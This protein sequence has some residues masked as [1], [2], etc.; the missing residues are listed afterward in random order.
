MSLADSVM[1]EMLLVEDDLSDVFLI[2]EALA[3][4]QI[5]TRLHIAGDGVEA[6][7]FL[8]REGLHADAPRPTFVLLDLNMPRK[9]GFAVL[10]EVKSDDSLRA[11]PV[12]VFST[13]QAAEQVVR[14]YSAH[15]NAYVVKP[16]N[17]DE[18]A[19]VVREIDQFYGS[20]VSQT[21]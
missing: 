21:M 7:A 3:Q 19:N 5:P 17:Y 2:Q 16:S 6:M 9:D 18:Y 4:W 12:I 13:S 15:A 14:C 20:V 1:V 10:S 8:R 11:I